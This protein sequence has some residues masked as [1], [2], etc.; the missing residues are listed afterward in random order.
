MSGRAY[1]LFAL[2]AALLSPVSV[3]R[4]QGPTAARPPISIYQLDMGRAQVWTILGRVTTASGD[5]AGGATVRV[6]ADASIGP[7]RLLETNLQG[8]FRTEYTLD[9]KLYAQIDVE[10]A[11][12][13]PGYLDARE[14][15]E[16]K[17]KEGT[18]E[19]HLVLREDL[20]GSQLLSLPSLI[21]ALG[22]HFRV[23]AESPASE[24]ARKD[25]QQG[26]EEFLDRHD[27]PR[28]V[29]ILE[30]AVK[31]EPECF[32][33]RNLLSLALLENGGWESA[34][35]LLSETSDAKQA[36]PASDEGAQALT[37][38]GVMNT[39]SQ[40]LRPALGYFL[41][42]LKAHPDDALAL[43]EAGRTLIL[44]QNWEAAD[45]YLE[46]AIRAGASEEAHLLRSRALL[47][48][49][50]PAEAETEMKAYLHGRQPR[51]L[52]TQAR[53]FYFQLRE[54]L[55]L[56]TYN[57][58]RSVVSQPVE[59]LT[60]AMPE[61]AG[62]APTAPEDD[63][64]SILARVGKTV[65]DFF[66]QLPNTSSHEEIREEVL[67]RNGKVGESQEEKFL[68]LLVARGE[69]LGLE[70]NEYRTDTEHPDD[71]ARRLRTGF[72]RTSG[73]A[74]TSLH[75]HP[76]FQSG[77]RF[78]LLGRQ[79]LEGTETIVIGFAQR[80]DAAQRI[81]RF[82]YNGKSAPVLLQGVAWV[83]A[84]SFHI[85]RLRTDLLAPP[86][87]T[88]LKRQTTEIQYGPVSFKDISSPLWLPRDVTV[89]VEWK[90]KTF[91]NLH[92][93]S[94]FKIFHVETKETPKAA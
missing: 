15:A 47:E 62:L 31:R 12:S 76:K 61:L 19:F 42:A 52:L 4:A 28:A 58:V 75:F 14:R 86:P 78:R 51:E 21:A 30:R 32:R 71:Q 27:A 89:T 88:R 38:L 24:A 57:L 65:E 37:I 48:L 63:L 44:Q 23:P 67:R 45:E 72:M 34:L 3:V 59:E 43:Q 56:Q 10:V 9:T 79:S 49:S 26:L 40:E 81:A 7:A 84:N 8:E 29:E 91:R 94:D 82:D 36:G 70:L 6:S 50:D 46:R 11:A 87:N 64:P 92:H 68:Y 33:C 83:D 53:M 22:P 5:P 20:K 18:R 55:Q 85:V 60:R 66:G 2:F 90:G 80:P 74:C 93:Y 69:K 39:W 25:Y 35:R 54:R 17:Q 73:F 41:E 1:L 77:A 13:K 16:F